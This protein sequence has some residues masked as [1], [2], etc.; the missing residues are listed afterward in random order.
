M[1]HLI[2]FRAMGCQVSIQLEADAAGGDILRHLPDRFASLEALLTRFDPH[3][4]LMR[5]N[6]RD[7]EWVAVSEVLFA[8]IC[9]A[10]Q[11]ALMTD[12]LYNPLILPALVASGYDCSFEQIAMPTAYA[13]SSAADWHGIAL[14]MTTQEVLLPAGSAIDLGGIAKGW[15]AATIA[16]ELAPF[17]ACLV[18]I[19]GDMVGRGAPHGLPGWQ[20]EIE[21]PFT[22]EAFTSVYLADQSISTSGTDY[23]RWQTATGSDHHHIIDPRSGHSAETDVLSAT[24]IHPSATT[25]EAYAKA[26]ILQ[27]VE[28]GLQW[29]NQQ[30]HGTGVVF[31]RDGA[32]FATSTFIHEWNPSQ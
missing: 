5:L 28:N 2:E 19:G 29:L 22:G 12:G 31:R 1:I 6:A 15:T 21:D 24:V 27:G 17:G 23:R 9:A 11:A 16:D 20:V 14:R 13:A 4:E 7:G 26:I 25:S 18:N 32:A 30:W 8:N 3:S 10:K